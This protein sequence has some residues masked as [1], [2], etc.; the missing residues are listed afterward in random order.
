MGLGEKIMA[1]TQTIK[2]NP[3]RARM[4]PTLH[5]YVNSSRARGEVR[6]VLI[7]VVLEGYQKTARS[8]E[9]DELGR[10]F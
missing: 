5:S 8:S 6:M 2:F 3:K 10:S 9:I 4:R 7:N 1:Q